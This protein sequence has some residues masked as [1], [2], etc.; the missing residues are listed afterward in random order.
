MQYVAIGKVHPERAS[1]FFEEVKIKLDE[2]TSL[3]VK[4][5]AGQL[6]AVFDWNG[7]DVVGAKLTIE[8]HAQAITSALGFSL[9]CGYSVEII[10][11]YR[12]DDEHSPYT[13]GVK[14]PNE[15]PGDQI[16]LFNKALHFSA[17]NVFFRLALR[18]YMRALA[19]QHD[20]AFYC[21]RAIEAVSQ[22]FATT[23]EGSGWLAMHE[24][25]GTS[26]DEITEKVKNYADPV[27]HGNWVEAQGLN[28]QKRYEMLDCTHR[29]L[30]AFLDHG[31]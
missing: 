14:G 5:D 30:V 28:N 26:K 17:K 15:A 23:T 20:C 1:A 24:A 31:T 6:S 18:D 19:D 22:S 4:C 13:F 12:A 9:N 10:S 8:H 25:L 3:R 27:R 11:I 29:L 21:Y 16:T 7:D 2:S